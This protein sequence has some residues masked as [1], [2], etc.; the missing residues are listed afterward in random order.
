MVSYFEIQ[1]LLAVVPII[2]TATIAM[3]QEQ[4]KFGYLHGQGRFEGTVIGAI[5]VLG[6]LWFFY[7]ILDIG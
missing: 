1:I 6:A 4:A 5:I 3:F 2:G 7:M